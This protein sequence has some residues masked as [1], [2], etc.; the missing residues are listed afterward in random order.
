MLAV[1]L[2]AGVVY[3]VFLYKPID[4]NNSLSGDS[5]KDTDGESR[6]APQ[7]SKL[8]AS[9]V[10]AAN[11]AATD[12]ND[13]DGGVAIY[14]QAI[15]SVEDPSE[16]VALLIKQAEFLS[17]QNDNVAALA[18]A[19]RAQKLGGDTLEIL[20]MIG[21]LYELQG[22]YVDAAGY[23]YKTA[24]VLSK[25]PGDDSIINLKTEADYY[26]EK[27]KQLETQQ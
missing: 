19:L 4:S 6:F 20:T 10:A 22:D 25:T 23:Y 24:D 7:V 26:R 12:A 9:T 16:K 18:V 14:E 5:T 13:V 2:T 15:K 27:A 3:A 11:S 8:V 21:V 17:S 1:L